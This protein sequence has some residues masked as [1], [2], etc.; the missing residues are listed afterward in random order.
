MHCNYAIRVRCTV[1]LLEYDSAMILARAGEVCTAM[2][3]PR[4]WW[5]TTRVGLALECRSVE[6]DG[7]GFSGLFVWLVAR[8]RV[9][10]WRQ[11][12]VFST[13][14]SKAR[15]S[16][17]PF[18]GFHSPGSINLERMLQLTAIFLRMFFCIFKRV[19]RI[20]L[21]SLTN[22]QRKG[23]MHLTPFNKFGFK[24]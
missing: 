10:R 8:V 17:F 12:L 13:C 18:S 9:L 5:V 3:V 1:S 14:F 2:I 22:W 11:V 7:R 21:I 4:V 23:H 24:Y 16:F 6:H 19:A 15:W 20:S